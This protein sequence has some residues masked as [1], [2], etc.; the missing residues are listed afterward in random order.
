LAKTGCKIIHIEKDQL[1]VKNDHRSIAVS[2]S[3][4]AFLNIRGLWDKVAS[5]TQAIKKVHVS[6]NGRY[7]RA[8]IVAKDENLRF[9]GAIA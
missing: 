9:L 5:K 8:E 1:Q 4:I 2:Y 7:G 6:D 3:S